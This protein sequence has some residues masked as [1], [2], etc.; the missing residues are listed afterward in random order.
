MRIV[1]GLVLNP[2]GLGREKGAGGLQ[3]GRFATGRCRAGR[4]SRRGEP[5]V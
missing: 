5:E 1:R 2:H 4:H 3:E